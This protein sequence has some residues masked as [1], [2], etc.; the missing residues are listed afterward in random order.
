MSPDLEKVEVEVEGRS[1][2][3]TNLAKVLYPETGFT[4]GAVID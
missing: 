4:K 3:L 1:L 2:V